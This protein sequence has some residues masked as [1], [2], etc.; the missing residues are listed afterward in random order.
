MIPE[1]EKIKT[2]CEEL[3]KDSCRKQ[4]DCSECCFQVKGKSTCYLLDIEL[5]LMR[6]AKG[7]N[8][9]IVWNRDRQ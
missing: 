3:R 2:I 4:A 5:I 6:A 1:I 9:R 7:K 8:E